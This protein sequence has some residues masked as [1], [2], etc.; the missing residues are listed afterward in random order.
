LLTK[1][2]KRLQAKNTK[3]VISEIFYDKKG[4][5]LVHQIIFFHRFFHPIAG[6]DE[7]TSICPQS[8]TDDGYLINR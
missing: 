2:D 3:D 4:S 6:S 5:S 1:E 8:G 7:K